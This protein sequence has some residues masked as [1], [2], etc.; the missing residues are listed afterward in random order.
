LIEKEKLKIL[1]RLEENTI[2]THH[3]YSSERL[4]PETW[5]NRNGAETVFENLKL[6]CEQLKNKENELEQ[7]ILAYLDDF[8]TFALAY[9]ALVLDIETV[10][11]YR[12]PFQ[13]LEFTATLYPLLVRLH[14]QSKLADLLPLLETT[15]VRVYK[16]KNTNPIADMYWL[17]S[18]VAKG[19]LTNAEITTHLVNFNEKFMSDH[20]FK[21]YLD[22]D[23]YQNGAVKY[24]LAEYAKDISFIEVYKGLQVEHIF[25]R[26]PDFDVSVYGFSEDY[27]YEKN[28]IG[29][30][31]LLEEGLNKGVSNKAPVNKV[32][33]YL[34]SQVSD[35]RNLGGAIQ[36]GTFDKGS[37]DTRRENVIGFCL[38]RF[39]IH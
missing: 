8:T 25:S 34:S 1:G 32:Q 12:K 18:E 26:E 17:S 30:L 19:K 35:M 10:P 24:I 11:G 28:R 16:L 15:E 14:M 4:F 20:N 31:G 29:N 39:K 33:G 27:D 3:Y 2:F 13:F 36:A 5:N 7:F 21:N 9:S 22:A 23:V 6:K 37:V 38:N